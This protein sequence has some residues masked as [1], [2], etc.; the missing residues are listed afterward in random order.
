MQNS[1]EQVKLELQTLKPTLKKRFK[2]ETIDIFGS[3][4]RNE[5]SEKSDIDL[6]ITYSTR[7][8]DHSTVYALKN[9]LRRKLHIK[10]DIISKEFL[11][12]H[13]KDQVLKE[14]VSV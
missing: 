10:V 9:Y 13:I 8:Y 14:A 4:A 7:D 3:Y 6:L 5:A 1:L 12:P 2:V 11:N